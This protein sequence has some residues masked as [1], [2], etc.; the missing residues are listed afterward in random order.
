VKAALGKQ[1]SRGEDDILPGS[2]CS[3]VPRS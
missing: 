1:P 2:V 3:W